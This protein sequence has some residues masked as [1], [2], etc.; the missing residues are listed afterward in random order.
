MLSHI[1]TF[2]DIKN[3]ILAADVIVNK[4]GIKAYQLDIYGSTDKTP[5]YTY[6]C[7]VLI[8]VTGLQD[9][10]KI[11]GF[12]DSKFV[13][14]SAWLV[15]NSSIAEGLPLALGE[16]GLCGQP[17]VC[18]EAGGSREVIQIRVPKPGSTGS[19]DE[20]KEEEIAYIGRSV[21]P[22]NPYEL[23]V[24]Q[25]AVLG[26]FDDLEDVATGKRREVFK[27]AAKEFGGVRVD[28]GA[29]VD[30]DAIGP[31][32]TEEE[33]SRCLIREPEI[34]R[35]EVEERANIREWIAAGRFED[36]SKRIFDK[37]KERRELGLCLRRHVLDK[38]SGERYLR[39]HEQMLHIGSFQASVSRDDGVSATPVPFSS[40]NTTNTFAMLR[41]RKNGLSINDGSVF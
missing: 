34:M 33:Y 36:I 35:E 15:L 6:E 17:I 1:V 9:H 32:N 29:V 3:A 22:S 39:E 25:L 11:R 38:F 19:N 7:T 18:T 24:A 40:T 4:F 8:H 2:K 30:A 5:W 31:A 27:R 13:L 16:A 21:S 26:V 37:K 23:A 20:G 41:N 10:V 12:G 28:S 14:N